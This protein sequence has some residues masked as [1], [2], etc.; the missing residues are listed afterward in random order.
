MRKHSVKQRVVEL[1]P[2]RPDSGSPPAPPSRAGAISFHELAQALAADWRIVGAVAAAVL[3]LA[4]VY[5]VVAPRIYE[6]DVV[7]RVEEKSRTMTG[8]DE[9]A[10]MLGE[11]SAADI[12]IEVIRSR[13]LLGSVVE[14]LDLDVEIEPRRFPLIGAVLARR[15]LGAEP[16]SPWM[17]L[18]RFAWGGERLGLARLEVPEELLGE[19]MELAALGG[20]RYRLSAGDGQVVVEG[21]LGSPASVPAGTGR[22]EITVSDLVARPKT[23]FFVTKR[24]HDDIVDA[25]QESLRAEEKGKKSGI[26]V[27]RLEGGDPARVAAVLDAVSEAYLRADV[28]RRAAEAQ[29][30]LEFLEA[31][32]PALKANLD[33]AEG[34]HRAFQAAKGTVSLSYETQAMV[35][36]SAEVEREISMLQMQHAEARRRFT[37]EHPE[38]VAITGKIATLRGRRALLEG[39]LRVL[40]STELDAARLQRNVKVASDLYLPLLAKAQELRVVRSGIVGNASI[41]DPA[42]RPHRPV[43]P[44]PGLVLVLGTLLGLGAGTATALGRR[45]WAGAARDADEIES[46]TGLPVYAGIPHSPKQEEIEREA[47]RSPEASLGL[48]AALAPDDPAVEQLRGL[49]TMLHFALADAPTKVVALSSP[50]PGAGKSFVCM[51]LAHLLAGAGWKVLLVDADLRR[52]QLHRHFALGG[53]SGL[54]ELVAGKVAPEEAIRA[55]SFSNLWLLPSGRV[56]EYPAELL[57]SR[58]FQLVLADA[59]RRYDLVIVDSPPVLAVTDPVLVARNAALTLLV[60]RAGQ[61]PMP[62]IIRALKQFAQNNVRVQGT[63]LNGLRAGR[64]RYG[65]GRHYEYRP[66]RG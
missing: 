27:V 39:R 14:Q 34:A 66:G 42:R 30:A 50:A 57:E 56:P 38:V 40:P 4:V 18:E 5:A 10:A 60:L 32:L 7:I 52:G 33:E 49:R 64:D 22:L 61:L 35:G 31:Q 63:I 54:A 51:N 3:A 8:L 36:R 55:T 2:L 45:T 1:A 48:L 20:G 12:E 29:R 11:K 47:R 21:Q 62:D 43:R 13:R 44:K 15:H 17:W 19:R 6:A 25:L 41:V 28:E 9:V 53:E 16:A 65:S 37:E 58:N 46:A 59:S 24:R 26:V 23:R